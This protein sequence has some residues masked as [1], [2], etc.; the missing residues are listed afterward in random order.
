MKHL[1]NNILCV[2]DVET[3]G[4]TPRYH[5]LIEVAILPLDNTLKPSR[6]IMPFAMDLKPR[7]P[8]NYDYE[9]L[10]A[11]RKEMC[12]YEKP[13][14]CFDKRRVFEVILSGCDPDRA[15]DLFFEWFENLRLPPRHRIMPIAHNWVFDRSFIMDWLGT[16][17]FD[18]CFDPRYRD[19]MC[20][21]LYDNDRA[22]WLDRDYPYPKNNLQYLCSQLK[23]SRTNEHRALDDCVATAEVFRR[24]VRGGSLL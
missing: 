8:E 3:T 19:T 24:I 21:S 11:Q 16:R 10:R 14:V 20:M 15:A 6:G 4:P 1:N 17:T 13:K 12:I 22:G 5:D 18:L 7:R 23:I 2:I 9:A